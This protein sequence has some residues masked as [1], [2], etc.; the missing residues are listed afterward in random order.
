MTT[1]I[2]RLE[3]D[4]I[5]SKPTNYQGFEYNVVDNVCIPTG[6][7]TPRKWGV[8]AGVF[9]ELVCG[10]SFLDIGAN[11]GFFCFKALE[12]GATK[13]TGI[14][15][16]RPY[17]EA[18]G[19]VLRE[20]PVPRLE[21]VHVRWPDHYCTADVVMALAMVHHLFGNGMSLEVILD[22]LRACA[23]EYVI[24]EWI[25]RDDKQVI[26]KG[27]PDRYPEYDRTNFCYLMDQRFS[28]IVYL[29]TSHHETRH[30][31]LLRK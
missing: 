5:I 17:W 19:N 18:L 4:T 28:D 15:A 8:V 3:N 9:P 23:N 10:K 20:N 11:F 31:Y 26:R 12:H 21:W 27:I 29:G 24:V 22:E 14:E 2:V 25:G 1:A 7:R 30:V 6:N 16:H 13:A